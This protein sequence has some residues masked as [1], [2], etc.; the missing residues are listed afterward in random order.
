[1]SLVVPYSLRGMRFLPHGAHLQRGTL[2]R[3]SVGLEAVGDLQADLE[4]AMAA[5]LA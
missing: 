1:M 3:L 4:Q 2:V 5:T